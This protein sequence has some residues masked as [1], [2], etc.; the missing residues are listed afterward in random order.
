MTST[1][2]SSLNNSE[3][4]SSKSNK[5]Y[6]KYFLIGD[7]ESSR[8]ITEYSTNLISPKEKKNAS[9]IFKRLCKSKERRYEENNI[10]TANE[11]K[12]YFSIFQPSI[13]FITYALDSYPQSL[14]FEMFEDIR[15]NN[16][17]SMINEETKELNP[18]GRQNLKMIIEKYQEKEKLKKFEE[19]Q[20]D[21]DDVKIEIKNNIN[22]MV[23]NI[24]DL[25]QIEDKSRQ[26]K[27]E[28]KEYMDNSIKIKN[29]SWWQNVKFRIIALSVLVIV[30]IIIL[31]YLI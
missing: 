26:L 11:N 6:I 22:K 2:E 3:D 14:I 12:Y 30:A 19:I 16:I 23:D 10:I 13:S 17:L 7:I 31:W 4:E 5:T 28:S 29:I 27:E 1:M 18:K 9:Q 20:K 8:I 15:R 21:I 24:E 25:D